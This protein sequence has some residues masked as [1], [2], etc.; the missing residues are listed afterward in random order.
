MMSSFVYHTQESIEYCQQCLEKIFQLNNG[1]TH[2][3]IVVVENHFESTFKP[4]FEEPT[5]VVNAYILINY[6]DPLT[7]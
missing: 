6:L 4:H 3:E 7:Y 2:P 1:T 5:K